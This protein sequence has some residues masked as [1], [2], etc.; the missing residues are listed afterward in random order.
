MTRPAGGILAELA[1]RVSKERL[2]VFGL[3][4]TEHEDGLGDGTLALL[5][6][7]EPGYWNHVIAQPEFRDGARDPV[8]RWSAR[9]IS[10]AAKDLGGQAL[11]PFGTPHRPFISWALRGGCY[12]SPVS[13]LVHPRAGLFVS[14]RGA[15]HL[16]DRLPLPDPVPNP[17]DT[18]A[19]SP[20]LTACPA[21]ALTADGYDLHGCHAYLD[22][23]PGQHCLSQGCAV[24]RI[25]PAGAAYQRAPEHS[26]YHMEQFHPCPSL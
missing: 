14:F 3:C 26:A 12:V 8:D 18:C 19:D 15:I 24:R 17:C 1:V 2:A 10:D 22:T 21:S 16:P 23:G 6:P 4:H 11:F 5:G 9:V 20:C 13:L 7:A 25:C